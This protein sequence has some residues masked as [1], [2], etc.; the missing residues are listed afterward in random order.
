MDRLVLPILAADGRVASNVSFTAVLEI[1]DIELA[2]ARSRIPE[3][4]DVV[5]VTS[6]GYFGHVARTSGSIDPGR[7]QELL[8]S[9][10]HLRPE[11]PPVRSVVLVDFI[12]KPAAG[13]AQ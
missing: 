12:V 7:L 11:L 2:A 4:R 3:Y 9:R 8:R 6:L 1:A 10:L 13:S 5:V